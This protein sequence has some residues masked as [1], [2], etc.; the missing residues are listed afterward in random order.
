MDDLHQF[1]KEQRYKAMGSRWHWLAEL[2][3]T[4]DLKIGAEIGVQLGRTTFFLVTQCPGLFMYAI[5]PWIWQRTFIFNG[6]TGL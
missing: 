5:D 3:R 2:V 4:W 1:I 6:M